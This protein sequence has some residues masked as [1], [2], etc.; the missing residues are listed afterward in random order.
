MS[1]TDHKERYTPAERLTLT[2]VVLAS[3]LMGIDMLIVT[4][5]LPQ[6]GTDLPGASLTGLQWV[7]VGY[8][9]AFGALIQPAGS[10][11]DRIGSKRMFIGGMAAFTLASLACGLAPDMLSLNA[12]RIVKGAA[13]AVMFANAMPL[14]AKTFAG[15]RRAMAIAVW[16]A[17]VGIASIAS[18]V[19]GG[20][21]V[22]A[23]GWRWM[24]LINV[25][26]GI[27]SIAIS[28]KALAPDA[29][30]TADRT[31]FD[32]PGAVAIAAGLLC[33]NYGIT[34]AQDDGWGHPVVLLLLGGFA[35]LAAVFAI[36]ETRTRFPVLDLRLL[37]DRTF[38]GVSLLAILNRIGTAG[39]TVYIMIYLQIG[40]GLS[41]FQ[42]GLLLL[43]LGV[44]ALSGSIWAG[45]LQARIA[46]RHV[47]TLGFALLAV[48]AALIGWQSAAVHEPGWLIPA[49]LVWGLGN[50][51][52]NTPLMNVATNAVPIER[53]GM[54]TGLINSFYPIGASLGT[55][56]LGNV[57]TARV[58]PSLD[59]MGGAVGVIYGLV[60]GTSLLAALIA[61]LLIRRTATARD[62]PFEDEP[63]VRQAAD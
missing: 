24:F 22:D 37:G 51:L 43:P 39:A 36:R 27:A 63:H 20:M 9:L 15:P 47:L 30:S 52:A 54:A 62:L 55:V 45:R 33:L 14:L 19:V 38:L 49:T 7:V 32:W 23:A 28:V 31:P 41:P 13:A 11:S 2:V 35:V 48:A 56:L 61:Y 12:F 34:R 10:L 29:R 59:A 3:A 17:V 21:L 40:H 44:A 26:L 25:P 8:A 46:P 6:I 60:A 58:G 42:T 53:V 1:A 18:P 50:A 57:F 4:V 16:A 5:A